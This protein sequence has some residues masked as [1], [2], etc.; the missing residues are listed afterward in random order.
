MTI[1]IQFEQSLPP[2][3]D[4]DLLVRAVQTTLEHHK[5][6][7]VDVTLQL[8]ND[9]SMQL[10]NHAYRGIDATTDVLAFNQEFVD[11]ETDRFY[12]GDIIISVETA[13][14]QAMENKH[15]LNR[16]CALLTIHGT[17][18]LLGYDHHDPQGK[19]EMWTIQDKILKDLMP[20]TQEDVE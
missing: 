14:F 18:H 20:N 16:E 2:I 13:Q 19:D 5:K 12:L 7:D 17:L 9:E 11:P 3:L 1:N 6:A 8:T 15:S 10:L 4:C